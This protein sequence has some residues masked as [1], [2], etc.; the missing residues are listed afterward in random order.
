MEDLINKFSISIHQWFTRLVS[1][2]V[3]GT[4]ANEKITQRM[5]SLL[6][7][8]HMVASTITNNVIAVLLI[9]HEQKIK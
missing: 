5:A 2:N 7:H 1:T 3:M 8:N 6:T 9:I 4:Q